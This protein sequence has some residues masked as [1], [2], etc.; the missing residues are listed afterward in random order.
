MSMVSMVSMSM[1][2]S[3]VFSPRADGDVNSLHSTIPKPYTERERE[4]GG[5]GG[6]G[7]GI[8]LLLRQYI[9]GQDQARPFF[10]RYDHLTSGVICLCVDFK[11]NISQELFMLNKVHL[12]LERARINIQQHM[13]LKSLLDYTWQQEC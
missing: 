12:H 6:G 7:V 4:E 8:K 2:M 3:H 13:K 11:F 5:V 9:L 1:V 10:H